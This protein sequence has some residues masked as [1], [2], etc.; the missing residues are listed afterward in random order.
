MRVLITG[1][2]GFAGSHLRTLLLEQ[3]HWTLFGLSR[4]APTKRSSAR[5]NWWQMDLL[6]ADA[7]RRFMQYERPD[8]VIHLAGQSHVPTSWSNPWQT[9]ETNV[10]GQL[11]LFEAILAA[12]LTPRILIVTSN[13]V[14]GAPE[15]TGSVP[16]TENRPTRPNNPYAVSKVAADAMALQYRLSHELD[17]VIA[18]PFNH[19]GP[20]QAARFVLPTFARQIAEIEA[21]QK[22]PLIQV[23]NMSAQRDFTDVRDVAK[24]YL[25]L[26]KSGRAGEPYNVCS[27]VPR[28]IQSLFDLMLSMSPVH[29]TTETDPTK[30]RQ[31][32]TPVSYGDNGKIR[33]ET[34]WHPSI[35][36]DQTVRDILSEWRDRIRIGTHTQF[37][38]RLTQS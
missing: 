20:G 15:S 23:G 33:M 24:G 4:V 5:E 9:F 34:G 29:I 18:R 12:K 3:T 32:D 27:G 30:L 25:G 28:S 31:V 11:N 37:G 13:E 2:S 22:A 7:V 16:F 38:P 21:G 19:C 14:Y 10:R 1:M 26:I 6:D 36:I 35:P 17:I 8:I